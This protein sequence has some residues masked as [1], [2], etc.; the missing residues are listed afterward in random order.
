MQQVSLSVVTPSFNQGRFIGE[1]LHS[2]QV[3]SPQNLQH[4][5]VDGGSNDET[6]EVISRYRPLP[7]ILISESD[8]GQSDAINKGLSCASG[9]VFNWLNS[10]DLYEP[11][12]L[13]VVS[14]CFS[15]PLVKVLCGKS[16]I[17]GASSLSV[18]S[19]TDVYSGNLAKTIGF[20][21][22]DQPETFFRRQLVLDAG[23]LDIRLHYVMDRHLWI[24]VLLNNGLDGILQIDDI[25]AR[26]RLHPASKTVFSAHKFVLE[27][28]QLFA[29]L[30]FSLGYRDLVARFLRDTELPFLDDLFGDLST[31]SD[32]DAIAAYVLLNAF[33]EAYAQDDYL[34]ARWLRSVLNSAC[35]AIEDQQHYK[36]IC[37][38]LDYLPKPLKKMWNRRY[39]Q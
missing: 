37:F 21:R 22:V 12:S 4:I 23:G 32:A 1:T 28:R 2:L 25:L 39:K 34:R 30:L 18:T 15:N 26:F 14:N 9:D 10:D 38:R 13:E 3:Q 5:I 24:K 35:L 36:K 19:G 8:L 27:N 29:G 11:G 17:F 7:H 6:L 31:R 16:I 20:A 33:L